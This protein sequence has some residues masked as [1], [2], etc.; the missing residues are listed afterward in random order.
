[1]YVHNGSAFTTKDQDNDLRYGLNCALYYSGAWWYNACYH[2][3][4]NGVFL[5]GVYAGV[6]RGVTWNKWK[7]D[8]YSMPFREM[9]IRPIG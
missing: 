7:G 9:K 6:Q 8:L 5:N 1:M 2:S 4:L 3:N